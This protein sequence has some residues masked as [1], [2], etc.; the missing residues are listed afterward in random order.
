MHEESVDMFN[1]AVSSINR[2]FTSIRFDHVNRSRGIRG[3]SKFSKNVQGTC[4][5]EFST[6]I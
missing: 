1:V 5:G 2:P 3:L 4:V 6:V